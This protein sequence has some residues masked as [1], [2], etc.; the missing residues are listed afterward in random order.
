LYDKPAFIV[1]DEPN[2]NLDADG[3]AALL[4]A[5]Q[6]LRQE[7]STPVLITHK[8]NVL[9]KTTTRQDGHASSMPP[10]ERF[11]SYRVR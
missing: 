7:G 4:S 1:L 10:R 5:V 3:V 6:Q 9:A 2:A 11:F 8:T